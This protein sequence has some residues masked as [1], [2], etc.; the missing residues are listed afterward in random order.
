M[1]SDSAEKLQDCPDAA[2]KPS[3]PANSEA[4]SEMLDWRLFSVVCGILVMLTVLFVFGVWVQWKGYQEGINAALAEGT[5]DHAAILS[6]NRALGAAIVKTSALFLGYL[7]VFTGAL[8]VLRKASAAYR[9]STKASGFEGTLQT[10]SPGLVIITLGVLLI[11]VTIL[12]KSDV[13]YTAPSWQLLPAPGAN[14]SD[15]Q[16]VEQKPSLETTKP[17]SETEK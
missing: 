2:E 17:P 5:K 9:L 13:E 3:E 15:S 14:E 6:Y 16:P 12:T 1:D 11:A 10:S 4:P 7:L 8:Y